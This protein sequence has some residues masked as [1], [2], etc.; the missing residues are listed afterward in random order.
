MKCKIF[1]EVSVCG[2]KTLWFGSIV[3]IRT[4]ES[5][6]LFRAK[7]DVRGFVVARRGKAWRR[8]R[9]IWRPRCW[10]LSVVA[11]LELDC[12]KSKLKPVLHQGVRVRRSC[13]SSTYSG[14][15][16]THLWMN[17]AGRRI[18]LPTDRHSH[19]VN[20][21]VA[22]CKRGFRQLVKN[23]NFRTT[24]LILRVLDT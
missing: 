13:C 24:T 18:L 7:L 3:A 4:Q 12:L 1:R 9:M 10:V 20:T 2:H 16:N 23:C 5:Y 14:R 15:F 19:E 22:C 11:W 6:Q 21:N 8:W 17:K